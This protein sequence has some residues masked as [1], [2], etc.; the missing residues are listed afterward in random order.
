[1]KKIISFC[2][3]GE[4]PI[5]NRGAVEN[6]KLIN[7]IYPEWKG[8]FYIEKKVSTKIK[9]EIK[10]HGSEVIE[11]EIQ[12]GMNPMMTRFLP[13]EDPEVD[14]W[15]SRDCDSR[16][17][18]KEKIA[19]EEWLAS[20]KTFHLMR[21]SHNH[22]YPIMGGM[23]GIK[24]FQIRERGVS[25]PRIDLYYSE[26]NDQSF[27][28]RFFWNFF[29]S[30]LLCHDTWSHKLPLSSSLTEREEDGVSWKEAYGVGLINFLTENKNLIFS[31]ILKTTGQVN[32]DF[33]EEGE[34]KFGVFVGQ[35]IDE[36][37]K[38]IIDRD[39][40]WEYEIRGIAYG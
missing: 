18:N 35:R 3:Y 32:K 15:I 22:Y 5:Y 27:L 36:K 23:F 19:V 14:V 16:I 6:A 21:D 8:R 30:D 29:S 11:F 37:N 33:P 2:L 24:N 28:E 10:I 9:N 13:L 12:E 40:R 39:T 17:S 7:E 20:G 34:C 4:S 38:P 31:N 26:G 25:V 1:M